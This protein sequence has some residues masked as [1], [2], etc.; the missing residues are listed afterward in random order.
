[1]SDFEYLSVLI[2]I[3]LGLG[4]TNILGGLAGLVRNRNRIKPYAPVPT[5]L[6]TLFLV[7]VQTWW[8][9]FGL[10]AIQHWTIVE[11]LVVLTQPV[12]LYLASAMLVPDFAGVE[13]IDLRA[14]YHRERRWFFSCMLLLVLFSLVRPVI[15]TGQ[16]TNTSDLI[17]HAIFLAAV[18]LGIVTENDNVHRVVAPFMLLFFVTYIVTLFVQLH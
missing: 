15:L 10:R 4:I 8:T 2:S 3:V 16:L 9:M 17:G 18:V 14:E 12:F 7:H 11:F 6:V 5:T 13:T 1:M